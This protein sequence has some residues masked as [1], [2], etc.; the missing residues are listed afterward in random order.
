MQQ[1]VKQN[2]ITAGLVSKTPVWGSNPLNTSLLNLPNGT[3]Y[4]HNVGWP[5]M[6]RRVRS[7]NIFVCR[8]SFWVPPKYRLF[9]P[10]ALWNWVGNLISCQDMCCFVTLSYAPSLQ[11]FLHFPNAFSINWLQW[12]VSKISISLIDVFVMCLNP[13]AFGVCTTK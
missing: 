12:D 13:D 10:I 8:L 2:H 9:L 6:I 3:V 4:K 1:L 7:G 5:V 11:I